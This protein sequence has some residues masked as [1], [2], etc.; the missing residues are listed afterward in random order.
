MP[1]RV[2]VDTDYP[3]GGEVSILVEPEKETEFEISL[4][5]PSFTESAQAAVNGEVLKDAQPGTFL[6]VSRIWKKGDRI[7]LSLC[8]NP[9]LVFGM[10]NPEDA[11]S[12]RHVA[13]LYGPLALARDRRLGKERLPVLLGNGKVSAK[14]KEKTDISCQCQFDVTLGGETF[15]MVDY[16]SAGKTWRRD[17]RMEVWMRI[18]T[19]E[20]AHGGEGENGF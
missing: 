12:S 8:W 7:C 15:P 4:R 13:V 17:S 11:L 6:R 14:K 3:A 19:P 2:T 1:V 9:R 20:Q 16:A 10:E 5:I 18:E